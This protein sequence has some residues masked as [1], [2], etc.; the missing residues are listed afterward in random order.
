M[1]RKKKLKISD[2]LGNVNIAESL[3][4]DVL[5]KI[6]TTVFENFQKDKESRKDWETRS[7]E[8]MKLALQ[9]AEEKNF[10]WERASNV[11]YPLLTLASIQFASRV[12]L[13]SGPDIVRVKVNGFDPKGTKTDRA[14]R[15]QKHM[16]YQLTTEMETWEDENDRL[17]HALPIIGSFFKKS[18]FDPVK[19]TNCSTLVWPKDLVFDYWAKTVEDCQ[20]KTEILY[21]TPNKITERVRS[22]VYR[23]VDLEIDSLAVERPLASA[24]E[25]VETYEDE[26]A[27][28]EILEQHTFWDLDDDGYQEPYIITIDK[29]TQQVFRIVARFDEEDI[30]YNDAK[31][32]SAITP[33][34]YYTQ[35]TFIP[36]PDGGNLG[37]GFGHLLG[38][39]NASVNTIINQLI[40][41]GT[42]SNLQ[43]GFIGKGLRV[44]AGK[45]QFQPGEW[46]FVQ[47]S[48]E[49]INKNI[50]PMPVRDPSPVLFNLLNLLVT[51]GERVGSVTDAV[52]GD[53]PP[54][55]QPATTTLATIEQGLKVFKRVHKRLYSSF[56]KEFKK[57][58]RLNAKYLDDAQYFDI[59]DIT[60][61]QTEN[62]LPVTQNAM[63]S[64]EMNGQML[65]TQSDYKAAKND[66]TPSADPNIMTEMEKAK[67][68]E[69]LLSTVQIFQ[70]PM[71]VL[72]KRY[73]EMMNFPNSDELLQPV[74]PGPPP[75]E[76][77]KIQQ[78]G[79]IAQ[80][81]MQ[82]KQ[83]QM[84]LDA[85]TKQVEAQLKQSEMEFKKQE[86]EL[87][88]KKLEIEVQKTEMEVAKIEAEIRK[89]L[90]E[91]DTMGADEEEVAL[92]A[93]K[94]ELE[95]DKL[96]TEAEIKRQELLIKQKELETNA[97]LKNKEIETGSQ[98][99]KEIA[100]KKGGGEH[101]NEMK[102]MMKEMHAKMQES[103]APKEIKR[104]K[105]GLIISIGNMKVTRDASGK[106]IGVASNG[107][108]KDGKAKEDSGGS[109]TK[110]G[111]ER[112]KSK[113]VSS[114]ASE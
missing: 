76:V 69:A 84:Q 78:E 34:E 50:V 46:K 60:A 1:A 16:T 86:F 98:T 15:I 62:T 2:I 17:F 11:K 31:E 9:V 43:S 65:V 54:T 73:I 10:P 79:K 57:L 66:V 37:L 24:L 45:L 22:G 56:T 42:L 103:S 97:E 93:A 18:Y 25:G 89:I 107:N 27:P 68:I 81:E 13:F 36:N 91:I 21:L 12:D 7:E 92:E 20:R 23:D 28:R 64:T 108:A 90:A 110:A 109:A 8:A 26:N 106:A 49:D 63:Q 33:T 88:N 75:P 51:A 40:D 105:N 44:K 114:K 14:L 59:L 39:I 35:F 104:D 74:P 41:S 85:Q 95:K 32:I 113:E 100:D 96:A 70:W 111:T 19:K 3:S 30:I 4:D 72:K 52:V 48:G 47:S 5:T 77:M 67:K 38:P 99:Q 53:N 61:E 82:L 102:G 94:L 101:L 58:F 112:K 29:A 80:A 6:G 87:E 83:A 71:D 55:N